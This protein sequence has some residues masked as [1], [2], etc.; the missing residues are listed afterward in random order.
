MILKL[1]L[2]SFAQITKHLP[3]HPLRQPC[4]QVV[5]VFDLNPVHLL[6]Q[7]QGRF[8]PGREGRLSRLVVVGHRHKRAFQA[9]SSRTCSGERWVDIKATES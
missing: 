4:R 1:Y 2:S 6:Q 7:P 3:A 5:G 8:Q 9:C